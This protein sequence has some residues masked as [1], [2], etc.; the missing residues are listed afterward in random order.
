M[1]IE[2][3]GI[4]YTSH[5]IKTKVDEYLS[6]LEGV[7]SGIYS[8]TSAEVNLL[9]LGTNKSVDEVINNLKTFSVNDDI[10][11]FD[12]NT[13]GQ[14]GDDIDFLKHIISKGQ[15]S[16]ELQIKDNGNG[17]QEFITSGGYKVVV[18][19]GYGNVEIFKPDGTLMTKIWGDPHVNEY[20]A[21]G[22][23]T[24]QWHYA[25][26]STFILA[27][28]TEIVMNS[29]KISDTIMV[30]R[31]VYVKDG[32]KVA[33]VGLEFGA[34]RNNDAIDGQEEGE[35]RTIRFLDVD[36]NEWDAAVA[37]KNSSGKRNG[38]FAE[39]NGQW[40]RQGDDGKFYDMQFESWSSYTRRQGNELFTSDQA[41]LANREQL[42]AALDGQDVLDFA[43]LESLNLGPIQPYVENLFLANRESLD[44]NTISALEIFVGLDANSDELMTIINS[45]QISD[46]ALNVLRFFKNSGANV[47]ELFE[48]FDH[49]DISNRKQSTLDLFKS[50]GASVADMIDVLDYDDASDN[51]VHV[52]DILKSKGASID[53]LFSVLDLED[54]S[55]NNVEFIDTLLLTDDSTNIADILSVLNTNVSENVKNLA[56]VFLTLDGVN[57]DH[58]LALLNI[59]NIADQA[60]D[61]ANVFIDN[62]ASIDELM[63][64]VQNVNFN[65]STKTYAESLF[66]NGLNVNQ[67]LN[68]LKTVDTSA[69]TADHLVNLMNFGFNDEQ[70][71]LAINSGVNSDQESFVEDVLS[72]VN[73][74]GDIN[75]LSPEMKE[76]LTGRY[77]SLNTNSDDVL[78]NQD[79]ADLF[80]DLSEF[81]IS[82]DNVFGQYLTQ[83]YD[84]SIFSQAEIDVNDI[85]AKMFFLSQN[86]SISSFI[87]DHDDIDSAYKNLLVASFFETDADQVNAARELLS[88]DQE[89]HIDLIKQMYQ[90]SSQT[91]HTY[92]SVFKDLLAK[93]TNPKISLAI[94]EGDFS[95]L[96]DNTSS[97]SSRSGRKVKTNTE[98]EVEE[99]NELF[100]S[101]KNF[102]A[103][104]EASFASLQDKVNLISGLG[105]ESSGDQQV[106]DNNHQILSG[107]NQMRLDDLRSQREAILNRL[108]SINSSGGGS[109]GGRRIR[110]SGNNLR[111]SLES[112]L[113]ILESQI[114]SLEQMLGL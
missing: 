33:H 106:I 5:D 70:I 34:G 13:N 98:Q 60:P 2:I 53:D 97:E 59:E 46:N 52:L 94:Y 35:Y 72:F 30:N 1:N 42:I 6:Y 14:S 8:A 11:N 63:D 99:T 49:G 110:G 88:D 58:L 71:S 23:Y 41:V 57:K 77:F 25:D 39:I 74:V 29:K 112:K 3:N 101:I 51:Q 68:I 86:N 91:N 113:V 44:A 87:D 54:V 16:G 109:S 81:D 36:A 107:I 15:P 76:A 64:L 26:D 78:Y 100:K 9:N 69:I 102:I 65:D 90:V 103:S 40:A 20:D 73:S 61:V 93:V 37:E 48:V 55:S 95:L 19:R 27:D 89:A 24:G 80:A 56:D 104:P 67:V 12:F 85:K 31:G 50:A 47:Q 75:L 108:A 7:K 10:G 66:N 82:N 114:A 21:N 18:S 28:G 79:L 96:V 105:D 32:D 4:S 111:N 92:Y 38:V 22:N 62:G 45:G 83:V 84:K 43:Q 17:S